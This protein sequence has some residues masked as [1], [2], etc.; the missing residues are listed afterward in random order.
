MTKRM[1]KRLAPLVLILLTCAGLS[2]GCAA[3]RAGVNSV[4]GTVASATAATATGQASQLQVLTGNLDAD[5]FRG[6]MSIRAGLIQFAIAAA[7]DPALTLIANAQIARFNSAAAEV[8]HFRALFG[9]VGAAV[10][11]GVSLQGQPVDWS[12]VTPVNPVGTPTPSAVP[13]P[14]PKPPGG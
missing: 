13:S 9:V 11:E 14:T 7:G 6:L 8:I 3:T 4:A 1:T 5:L 10:N 12:L 2:T